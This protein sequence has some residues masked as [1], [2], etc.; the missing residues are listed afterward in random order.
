MSFFLCLFFCG[1]ILFVVS[2]ITGLSRN[3]GAGNDGYIQLARSLAAG[4]GYVF[5]KG[6]P[7]VFHRPPLYP[8]FLV[9]VA[10]FPENLQRY[11]III[12][13]S[14][15]VGFIGMMIF[16]IARQLYNQTVGTA[17][18]LFFLINPWVYWNAKNPMAAVLQTFLYLIF[19]YF[20]SRELFNKSGFKP[21]QIGLIIGAA[22]AG[23]AL[24]HAAMLPAVLLLIGILFV[25]A[26][27]KSR[28]RIS[29]SLF[30]GLVVICL[31]APWTYRNW[32]V[33]HKFIPVSGG[34]GL[35]Y[36]NGNVHWRGIEAE[37]QRKGESYID[38]SLMVLGI[39]GTETTA[40]HWKGFKDIA[41]EEIANKK[42]IEHIKNHPLLFA[43]KVVL[44]ST[45][46]Y[47]PV[48]T[49]SFLAIKYVTIERWGLSVFHLILWVPAAV[50]IFAFRK[51][52]L[53]LLVGI[54][55]YSI[56]YFPFATFI[57][58][59]LYTLGTIPFLSIMAAAGISCFF[60]SG[61]FHRSS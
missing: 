20:S 57:G 49:K 14:V 38:A 48:F 8:L 35:A 1:I 13:Q 26:L 46:Y 41:Q 7:P 23:L 25:K 56:W 18:L 28:K 31:I 43:K 36:F 32:I 16:K 52:G 22:G 3:F 10:I 34:G 33:F 12:P 54:V 39:E 50:G 21:R 45:E 61:F 29:V 5:E 27:I 59:S 11:V 47:F 40:T 9:P 42:M 15:L 30:A 19:A 44:N 60:Q 53:L 55:C 2:P 4:D 6:G 24:T 58:H 17:A 51:E 37:P